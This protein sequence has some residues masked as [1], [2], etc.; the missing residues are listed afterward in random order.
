MQA[1]KLSPAKHRPPAWTHDLTSSHLFLLL[2]DTPSL[3]KPLQVE[4]CPWQVPIS[5]N[6]NYTAI[7]KTNVSRVERQ[8]VCKSA[9]YHS[10]R[11]TLRQRKMNLVIARIDFF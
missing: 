5:N 7:R 6:E 2:P 11:H 10:E 4:A 8:Y 1:G 3:R 9:L